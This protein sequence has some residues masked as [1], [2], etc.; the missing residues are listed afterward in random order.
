ME[1]TGGSSRLRCAGRPPKPPFQTCARPK[2]VGRTQSSR[3]WRWPHQ[4]THRYY[5]TVKPSVRTAPVCLLL[6]LIVP[7]PVPTTAGRVI[8]VSNSPLELTVTGG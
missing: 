5:V 4:R 1:G 8:S 6:M 7:A 3:G 2:R